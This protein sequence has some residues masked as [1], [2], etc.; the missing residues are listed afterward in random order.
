MITCKLR[1]GIGNQM[2]QIAAT[3]AH[4]KRNS[5]EAIFDL[6]DWEGEHQGKPAAHYKDTILKNIPQG[7]IVPKTRYICKGTSDLTVLSYTPIDYSADCILDGLFQSEKYFE[8]CKEDIRNLFT[9]NKEIAKLDDDPEITAVCVRRGDYLTL[10]HY[11]QLPGSY[12]REAMEMIGSDKPFVFISD[13][14]EW[15][16]ETFQGPNIYY[17]PLTDDVDNMTLI[18]TCTNVILAN[19]TFGWWGAWLGEDEYS[20]I[21]GPD[22]WFTEWSN[23]DI[24]PDRWIKIKI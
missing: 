14:M 12:Y 10:P 21:I 3:Y 22:K 16:K 5:D 15:C 13:D 4:A 2:F 19:S 11:V 6:D 9:L 8:D 20:K 1:N 7:T 17:S 23:E 18:A 24:M